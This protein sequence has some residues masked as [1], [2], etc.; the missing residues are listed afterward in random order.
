MAEIEFDA[1]RRRVTIGRWTARVTWLRPSTAVGTGEWSALLGLRRGVNVLIT[2]DQHASAVW[3]ELWAGEPE[4]SDGL[5]VTT[6]D[7]ALQGVATIPLCA[8]GD[9]GCG[10][11]GLQL[12]TSVDAL[13]LPVVVEILQATP[14]VPGPPCRGEVWHGEIE[15][16]F[17]VVG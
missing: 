14:D 8:C 5:A 4:E 16:G 3:V 17:P 6:A 7:D 11:V 12:D 13:D 10:N 15:H 9:R 2:G 1:E